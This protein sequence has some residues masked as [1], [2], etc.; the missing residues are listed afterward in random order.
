MLS[1]TRNI[2]N[3]NYKRIGYHILFW[4]VLS[5]FYDSIISFIGNKSFIDTLIHDLLYFFPTDILGVYFTIYFLIPRFL[6]KKKYRR[7]I[8]FFFAFFIFLMLAVTMPLQYFGMYAEHTKTGT[9]VPSFLEYAEK[10]LLI[11]MTV[12]LMIIGI[13]TTIKLAKVWFAS[14]KRQQNLMNEKL[15]IKLKLKEAELKF[16]KSQINPHFL[17]N[18]LNNLYGLTLEKSPKAPDVVL[19]ISSLLD[20]VLYECN[21]PEI[22]LSKEIENLKRY[23]DL[24]KIRYDDKVN[25]S[26]D[27]DGDTSEIKIAPLLILPL[28]ENSFKHGLEKDLGVGFI[29]IIINVSESNDFSVKIINSLNG[30][31]NHKGEGIGLSNLRRR[32]ELQYPEKHK[33]IISSDNKQY[34]AELDIDMN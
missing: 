4:V 29:K 14:Q 32:L 9:P 15:E 7:F 21:V 33:L 34:T 31:K 1:K 16:L 23:I 30:E 24:Q 28:I 20:Y 6:L 3:I 8:L 2:R 5:V 13:A 11:A 10:N 17:F 12:K 22:E 18:A 25:I 27:I 26:I 19:K